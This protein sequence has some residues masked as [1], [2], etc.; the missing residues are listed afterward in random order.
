MRRMKL[1][2]LKRGYPETIADPEKLTKMIEVYAYL[3]HINH[4]L[5]ISVGFFIDIL[6]Y[7]ILIK[8]SREFLHLVPWF[9]LLV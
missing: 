8:K 7:L 4:Y 2:F 3:P 1:C 6:V 9:R 5:K